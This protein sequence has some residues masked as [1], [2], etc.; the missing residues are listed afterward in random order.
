MT[1]WTPA[2]TPIG[3][4]DG[5]VIQWGPMLQGDTALAINEF[6]NV[7]GFADRSVQAEGVFGAGGS[8]SFAGSNDG[9]NFEI[10]ND[11]SSVPL[12]FNTGKIRVV[13]EATRQVKPILAG[14][15]GTTAV[16]VTL[17]VRNL[18]I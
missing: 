13:L 15:D 10:L 18:K 8:V 9:I 4:N 7:V 1:I 14:G 16:T 6:S 2:W 5:Y 17:F 3:N 11:A 12:T